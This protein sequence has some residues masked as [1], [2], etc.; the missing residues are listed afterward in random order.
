MWLRMRL[1]NVIGVSGRIQVRR[2]SVHTWPD[3][4]DVLAVVGRGE[5]ACFHD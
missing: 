3:M 1:A 5:A 4:V 2:V